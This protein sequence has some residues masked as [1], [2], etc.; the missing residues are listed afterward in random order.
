MTKKCEHKVRVGRYSENDIITLMCAR[1]NA[2][3]V[4]S[5]GRANDDHINVQR[6]IDAA[7]H[8][9]DRANDRAMRMTTAED[10]GYQL[11]YDANG[12]AMRM[13]WSE[14]DGFGLKYD[15]IFL[16][17]TGW[18]VGYLVR[19]AVDDD[20]TGWPWDV[21][22]PVAGQFEE[23]NAKAMAEHLP[24]LPEETP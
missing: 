14:S 6:E 9:Q 10:D 2:I 24:H 20:G 21:T 12:R 22:R 1:C 16:S 7:T 23:R 5:V 3:G 11:V 15:S 8:I 17:L 13:T 18:H 4:A 19:C